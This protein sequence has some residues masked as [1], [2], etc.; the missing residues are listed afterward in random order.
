MIR[1]NSTD[2][3]PARVGS[4]YH[5]PLVARQS[6]IDTV[7]RPCLFT[8]SGPLSAVFCH[9]C[10]ATIWLGGKANQVE[11]RE[12]GPYH[13]VDQRPQVATGLA[14]EELSQSSSEW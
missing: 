9:R 10:K 2:A 4:S 7:R 13:A 11:S 1:S 3:F 14:P 5:E 6:R 8:V 12:K